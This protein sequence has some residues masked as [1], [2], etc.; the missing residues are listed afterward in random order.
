MRMSVAGRWLAV[1]SL[2]LMAAC[3]GGG[4]GG[5]SGNPSLAFSPSTVSGNVEQGEVG[6]LTTSV[7]LRNAEKITGDVWIDVVD[8][9]Q[10]LSDFNIAGIDATHFSVTLQ[11]SPA[12]SAGHHR[13]SVAIHVCKDVHCGQEWMGVTSLPY[14]INVVAG[15]LK[16]AAGTSTTSTVP[17]Q[18]TDADVLRIDVTG[19]PAW[20]ISSGAAWLVNTG[21][22]TGT[23]PASARFAFVTQTLAQPSELNVPIE[24]PS[25]KAS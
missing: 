9:Q 14:D 4:G 3:G 21:A 5:D 11:T 13:G 7:T 17:W 20:T 6:T 19:G 22:A 25:M 16:A 10:V 8:G 18:G 1:S 2:V 15:P 24:T 23:S 12:L